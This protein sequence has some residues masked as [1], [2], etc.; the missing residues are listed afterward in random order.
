M[1]AGM[2]VAITLFGIGV[3]GFIVFLFIG[4][5]ILNAYSNSLDEKNRQRRAPIEARRREEAEQ[6]ALRNSIEGIVRSCE[7]ECAS[8]PSAFQRA[9]TWLKRAQAEYQERAY[10][11][12]W[13]AVEQV[14]VELAGYQTGLDRIDHLARQYSDMA[15][16]LQAPPPPFVIDP[17]CLADVGLV[18][19]ELRVSVRAAQKDHEFTSIFLQRQTNQ[20]LASG[21][22][23]LTNALH[24]LGD[25]LVSSFDELERSLVGFADA[26]R[27]SGSALLASM[28]RA[29][30][31]SLVAADSTMSA[32][33]QSADAQKQTLNELRRIR[34]RLK[35]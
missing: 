6:A 17:T 14:A 3:I 2:D 1:G 13:D 15:P 18:L 24:Q 4:P 35:A 16:R 21:F 26:S 29:Q 7:K 34:G 27:V 8:L 19:D 5:P 23:S 28:D 9:S 10:I 22:G 11:P 32:L 30:A 25:R 20:I 33:T 31:A 12:Y